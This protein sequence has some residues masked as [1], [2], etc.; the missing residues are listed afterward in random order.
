[1]PGKIFT[2]AVIVVAMR[3]TDRL[4]GLVSTLILARLLLPDDFGVVAM[5]S[6]VVGLVDVLL[7]LSVVAALIHKRE[8]DADD[9][10]TAWTI[11][12][13]QAILAAAVIAL[14]APL[15]AGYFSDQRV[16]GVLWLMAVTTLAGGM[17]NIGIVAFQKE[18]RFGRDFQFFFLR[19]II[20][21]VATV[22]LAWSLATYWALPLGALVGRCAGV[23]L[24]YVLHPF[25]PRLTLG[26]FSTL[27]SFSQWMLVR[28]V[29]AYVDTRLDRLLIGHRADSTA[30]G[31]YT[32]ADEIAAMPSSE[33]L[34]PLGRV[35][36]PAFVAVRD[37]PDL[38]REAY[39]LALAV[40]VMIA[41]PAATGL[42]LV[43]HDAVALLLGE[44][45]LV[46]VPF[47]Q[48]LALVY[49]LGAITHAGGYLLLTLGRV[50]LMAKFIWLQIGVFACGALTFLADAQPVAL[51]QWRL[52]VTAAGTAGFLALVLREIPGLRPADLFAAI[53]R[54]IVAAG[55]MAE[56][57][58]LLRLD[59]WSLP[60]AL[61]FQCLA[62]AAVY[63]GTL[64]TLWQLSGRPAG[65][66]S[67]VVGKVL[68]LVGQGP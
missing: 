28:S 31:A 62:G 59:D 16:V 13:L 55:M 33:L 45:W 58:V 52:A 34:A 29:G 30:V 24:S 1:M 10:S 11:R 14:V 50:A 3:W 25:R 42:A 7:D 49:G 51:A 56:C 66:E 32:L 57:L 20:G 2:S 39:R 47:V 8:C 54:P 63:A 21:F 64:L 5:A 36:F 15:A 9:F 12:L 53:W 41:I 68:H 27:W 23:G 18:M 44:R 43:A 17:E 35:L 46:A 6:L 26:R 48:A 19:R 37:R 40:Q 38:L 67:Y 4:V 22:A 61:A 60:L 65:S